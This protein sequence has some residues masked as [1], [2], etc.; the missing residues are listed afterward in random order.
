MARYRMDTGGVVDTRK[1]Q[2]LW[3][4]S[5][6]WNGNNYISR[7]TG[8]QWEHEELYRSTKGRYYIVS[9]SQW[10]GTGPGET[11]YL[12]AREAAAWLVYHGHEI[13]ADLEDVA[14]DRATAD[15]IRAWWEDKNG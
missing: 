4:E 6:G 8:S 5:R 3:E 10:Q 7:A 11:R 13:P 2:R 1:A 9:W 14:E 15:R 12:D